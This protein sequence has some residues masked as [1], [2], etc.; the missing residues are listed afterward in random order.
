MGRIKTKLI[1]RT[2]RQLMDKSPEI[3]TKDFDHNKKTIGRTLPSKKTRNKIAGYL[4]RLTRQKKT[5]IDNTE[6]GNE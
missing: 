2:S 3:F 4:A 5:I 1:K 6:N